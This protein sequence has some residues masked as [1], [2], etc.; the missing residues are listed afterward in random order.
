[1]PKK[2]WV[3][4]VRGLLKREHGSGW[5]IEEQSG[6]VKFYR[7]LPGERKQAVT[8]NIPWA[9]GK[10]SEVVQ[11]FATVRRNALM[12]STPLISCSGN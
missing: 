3:D 2:N 1:M 12:I 4:D 9:A 7:R 6:K 5:G 10:Q 8:T 11:V